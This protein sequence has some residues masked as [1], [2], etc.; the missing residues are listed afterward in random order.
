MLFTNL[1][2][3]SFALTQYV[4]RTIASELAAANLMYMVLNFLPALIAMYNLTADKI[5]SGQK[6]L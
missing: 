4:L 6:S 5:Q 1:F 3:S 2:V